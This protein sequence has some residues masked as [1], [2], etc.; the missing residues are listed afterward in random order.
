MSKWVNVDFDNGAPAPSSAPSNSSSNAHASLPPPAPSSASSA[1]PS[2]SS[3]ARYEATEYIHIEV[4][5]PVK[6]GEGMHAYISYKI[7]T[8]TDRRQFQKSQFSVIRRFSDFVWLH[9]SLC[10]HYAGVVVPPLPEKLLVGR[11][12]PEFVESR[13]RALHLFLCRCGAHPEIQHS[14][15]LTTFLEAS[16]DALAQFKADKAKGGSATSGGSSSSGGSGGGGLGLFQYV[17]DTV[18]SI[19]STLTSTTFLDKLKTNADV[20]VEDI[21]AYMD[22]LEPIIQGLAKHAHGLTKRARE[23]ADGLFEYG[24]ALTLLGES[25]ENESL[26]TALR[27]VGSCADALSVLAAEHAEKEVLLFEEPMVDYIRLVG[28]VK[29]ALVKRNEVR[30]VYHATVADLDAKKATLAKLQAKGSSLDKVQ[31]AE[32]D[33]SKAQHRVDDAKLE[34][35][36]VTERV[37]REVDRFKQDKLNDFKRIVLDYVELQ[38]E[39]NTKVE[40]KWASVVP[41]LQAIQIEGGSASPGKTKSAATGLPSDSDTSGSGHNVAL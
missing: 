1:P 5:E 40:A 21:S 15:H 20:Q 4:G 22:A 3:S 19:S 26:Q 29:A 39:Y 27:Y 14:V 24:V 18:A 35:D 38:I 30:Q 2:S 9:A 28:A 41:K 17:S 32:S 33:V 12:S 37:V 36:I 10:A 23:I 16:D 13:R 31:S 25:E 6:Q 11:F 34:H 8:T 7:T